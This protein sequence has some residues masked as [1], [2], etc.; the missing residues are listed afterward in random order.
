MSVFVKGEGYGF[1]VAIVVLAR[2]R[3]VS[4]GARPDVEP[5]GCRWALQGAPS[6]GAPVGLRMRQRPSL[7]SHARVT[8][9]PD[10]FGRKTCRHQR[11]KASPQTQRGQ[12]VP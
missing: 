11:A 1:V 9:G 3:T 5:S 7:D 6:P 8:M 2:V 10:R 4:R 12:L